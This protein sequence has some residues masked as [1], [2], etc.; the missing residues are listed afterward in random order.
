M[1]YGLPTTIE[2]DGR[3]YPI[4]TDFRVI[5]EIIEMLNDP[6]LSDSDKAECVLEMFY[7]EHPQNTHEALKMCFEFMDM[8]KSQEKKKNSPRLMDWERDFSYIIAPVNRVL[9]FEA[10]TVPYNPQ[11]S[12]SGLHW[13]TFLAAYME[14]GGDCV[15]SQIVNIRDKMAR[16]KK[17][18]KY[19]REWLRKN[20][21]IVNL[22]QRYTK[23]QQE[24]MKQLG[25]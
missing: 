5:L 7:M 24:L 3:E 22:P 25:V 16:G 6:D 1:F 14:I 8:G 12:G 15:L 19:E 13:W 11:E 2:I 20:S 21:D 10:R 4:R 18:E 9:G 17:L 23:E